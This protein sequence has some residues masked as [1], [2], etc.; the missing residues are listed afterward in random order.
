M[1]LSPRLDCYQA[2][3]DNSIDGES[4]Y[5]KDE[6]YFKSVV[7]Q[8]LTDKVSFAISSRENN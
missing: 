4:Y 8:R 7:G 1:D 3:A 6:E 2:L 5:F